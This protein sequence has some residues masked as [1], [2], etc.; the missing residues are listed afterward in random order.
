MTVLGQQVLR[1]R[2]K[3]P[4]PEY[5]RSIWL[6]FGFLVVLAL[7]RQIPLA[8]AQE[9]ALPSAL[10]TPRVIELL[11]RKEVTQQRLAPQ[12]A[13][14]DTGPA[15]AWLESSPAQQFKDRRM[16][17]A[18]DTPE[19]LLWTAAIEH[20]QAGVS[21]IEGALERAET[22]LAS[23][24]RLRQAQERLEL[25]RD[26]GISVRFARDQGIGEIESELAARTR[27][28][29]QTTLEQEQKRGLLE[30]LE[31]QARLQVELVEQIR[32]EGVADLDRPP[33]EITDELRRT[34]A[35]AVWE[36][37]RDRRGDVRLLAAQLDSQ[38]LPVRIEVLQFELAVID[39]ELVWLSVLM[40]GIGATLAERVDEDLQN[41]RTNIRH[42]LEMEPAAR[43]WLQPE[44]A[45]LLQRVDRIASTQIRIRELQQARYFYAELAQDLQ[46]ALHAVRERLELGGLTDAI[47]RYLQSEARRVRDLSDLR[48]SLRER[49]REAGQ[50]RLS[51]LSLRQEM[52]SLDNQ[53]RVVIEDRTREKWLQ[54]R[55]ETVQMQQRANA[56]LVEQLDQ[57]QVYLALVVREV[58]T[59]SSMIRESMLWW[60]SHVPI[61]LEWSM[62]LPFLASAVVDPRSWRE[63]E[64]A[65]REV[66]LGQP[67][68]N[69]L[70]LLVVLSLLFWGRGSDQNL[71]AIAEKTRHRFT[72]RIG[73]TFQALGWTLLRVLPVPILLGSIGL[74]LGALPDAGYAVEVLSGVLFYASIWWLAGHLFLRFAHVD[75][76]GLAHL[77]WAPSVV[78][79]LR[80]QLYW[81]FPI[82]LLLLAAFALAFGHASEIVSDVIGRVVIIAFAVFSA[83]FAWRMLVPYPQLP[84]TDRL[85]HK[86]RITRVLV[87]LGIGV[88]VIMAL[89]GYLLTVITLVSRAVNTLIVLGA[90]WLGYSLA[91]RALVL[92]ETRLVVRRLREQRAMA[93]AGAGGGGDGVLAEIP[94]PH[95]SVE[96]INQQTRTLLRVTA[97]GALAIGL[98]WVWADI[99]PA[100]IW[101]DGI[102]LW[103]RTIVVGET[104]ILS[105]V[106]LQDF[107]LAI[108]LGI[109][110]TLAARNLPGL[111][112]I[113]LS[114]STHMDAAGRYTVTT[115][116]RYVLAVVAV[117]SVFSLLGLR[118][119]E[120]QWMVA[121]LTLGLGFGLQ[122]V[123]ANFVSGIIMLFERPVRVG[124]TI[125]IGEFSGTVAKI[126][127]RATTIVD[128]DNREIV[129]PNKAFITERLINWT[130]TDTMTRITVPVGVGYKSDVDEVMAVLREI[131]DECP[132]VMKDPAPT[133]FFLSFGNS[134][135]NFELRVYVNQ[136]RDRL[137]TTSDLHRTILR[138]FRHR[139]IEIA[140]PQMDLHLRD[141]PAPNPATGS[142][143]GTSSSP[144][145][146][147]S[148]ASSVGRPVP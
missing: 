105:R 132:Q 54:L 16:A 86:R 38:T 55:R 148:G 14:I 87:L 21:R 68:G 44:V 96:N 104:E 123:V 11:N 43:D 90:V 71:A 25:I 97:G 110:F 48:L 67:S 116:L 4:K 141:M 65:I 10:T 92:S 19:A 139:G 93:A 33:L 28:H 77:G 15:R 49:E 64:V 23:N 140:Y 125:T 100:L 133:V 106:S 34:E 50:A 22:A 103:S 24:E 69:F 135:L 29:T 57:S 145:S 20:E 128:W 35:F 63:L 74:R 1:M 131:A 70:T 137:M 117:I 80:R 138:E 109:L 118:W 73:L 72:D 108:F 76:V 40:Q 75:G 61:G 112:E 124:D 94:E 41:L 60:P 120:L 143:E 5:R 7:F 91:L 3:C 95:L 107:L 58:D 59:L 130:L 9:I 53:L 78:R 134:S 136:L 122:E 45:E 102:S 101:L 85:E 66:L 18:D 121:A 119:S 46:E 89:A 82:Q 31:G 144:A 83:V 42:L 62:R 39:I 2:R 98:L 81:F 51:D 88:L 13:A 27:Q 26:T 147:S 52:R 127:T 84:W 36:T 113:V 142:L 8:G 30:R 6:L 12:L 56:Q 47:G 17:V 32:Q 37:A 114:R 129:I 126:R 99:L 115:L 111:V 146:G 79:R